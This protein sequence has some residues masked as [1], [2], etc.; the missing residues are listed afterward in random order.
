LTCEAVVSEACFLLRRDAAGPAG[1]LELVSQGLIRIGLRLEDEAAAIRRLL[2]SYSDLGTS[3]ADV[4]L[5]RL[6]ELHRRCRVLTTDS[7]FLTY[8]R[9]RRGTIPVVMPEQTI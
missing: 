5:V 3:L 4:C 9:H 1:V 7:D 6:A 2:E 8:R